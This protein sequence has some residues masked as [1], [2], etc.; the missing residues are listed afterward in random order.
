MRLH[1]PD[2]PSLLVG[3]DLQIED[4]FVCFRVGFVDILLVVLCY[5][6]LQNNKPVTM[7]IV[8]YNEYIFTFLKKI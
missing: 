5:A 1:I 4:R 7:V 6:H 8:I 3:R 2:G